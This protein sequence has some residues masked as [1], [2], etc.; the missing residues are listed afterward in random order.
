MYQNF[1]PESGVNPLNHEGL[2]APSSPPDSVSAKGLDFGQESANDDE[3]DP[4]PEEVI[5]AFE[6]KIIERDELVINGKEQEAITL[7]N[8][9]YAEISEA[10]DNSIH[11][12]QA[13]PLNKKCREFR[14]K[15][16]E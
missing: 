8:K 5:E 16:G 11:R 14:E 10:M 13:A 4:T 1:G 15:Y 2:R 9:I 6:E 12:G 3:A 7:N